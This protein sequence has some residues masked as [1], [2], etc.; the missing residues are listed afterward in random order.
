MMIRKGTEADLDGV[1][2]GYEELLRYEKKHGAYT[3]WELGV[4]PTRNSAKKS[5]DEDGLYVLEEDGQIADSITVNQ[6]QPAEYAQVQWGCDAKP[7]EVIVIHLLCVRPS[8]AHRGLGHAMVQ[9]ILDEAR[10][11]GCKAVR[12]DTG[13]QNIPARSLYTKIGFH[14]AGTG[15]MAIGGVIPHDGHLFF[16][17][18]L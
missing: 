14:L 5:L 1:N 11:Q 9:F 15:S 6:K 18:V 12:L 10:K 17:Y 2:E 8:Q 13:A 7:E 4:Y 3:V 16:E